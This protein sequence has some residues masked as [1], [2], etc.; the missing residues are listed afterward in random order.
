LLEPTLV[1]HGDAVGHRQ[2]LLLVMRDDQ[3]RG[4][5]QV[6]DALDLDLHVEAQVLPALIRVHYPEHIPPVPYPM[7]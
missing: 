7:K 1:E 3:R 2:R 5:R 4:A 6:L